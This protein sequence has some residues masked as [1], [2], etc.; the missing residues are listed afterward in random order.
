M[1]RFDTI[2]LV[3]WSA[4]SVPATGADSIWILEDD[5]TGVRLANPPTRIE[6]SRQLGERFTELAATGR[7][8]LAGFD[9]PLGYPAHLADRLNLSGPPWLAI[10]RTWRRLIVDAEN[11]F[12][13]RFEAAAVLNLRITGGAGPFW[14]C[15]PKSQRRTLSS[16]KREAHFNGL[17]ELR[18]CEVRQRRT[19]SPFKLYAKG[20]PGSQAL[21]GIPMLT[22]LRFE[23]QF[24]REA[25]VWPFETGFRPPEPQPLAVFA[26]VYPSMAVAEIRTGEVKDAAQ[27]RGLAAFLRAAE[28]AGELDTLFEPP[29]VLTPDEIRLVE[30]EEGWILGVR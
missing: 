27:L 25:R 11:N 9:F 24:G 17:A 26:E 15:P 29:A 8:T 7:R 10:W 2:V 16:R 13:N 4:S 3:D 28:G 5:E 12:N 19:Q 23:T 30:R 1:L 20:A 18:L 21:L 22:R 14:G 6:A